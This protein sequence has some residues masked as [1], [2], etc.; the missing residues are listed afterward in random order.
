MIN[1]DLVGGRF[2]PYEMTY[3]WRDVILYN[4]GIGAKGTD[5]HYVYERV[6]GGLKVCPSFATI[7]SY[8]PLFSILE[9]LNI[10]L[11][12]LLHGEEFIKLLKPIPTEGKIIT[13]VKVA[14]IYDKVK[15]ALVE[16]ETISTDGEGNRLFETSMTLFCRGL[17]GWGGDPGP[18]RPSY[19]VPKDR[20]AD[21][22]VVEKISE[23]QAAIYRLSGDYNPLHIDPDFAKAAGLSQP[24]LHGLCTF[25]FA[26][27][28][29]IDEACNGNV[30]KLKSFGCRFSSVV[31][32]GDNLTISG[33][34]VEPG[35]YHMRVATERGDALS[36]VRAEV[37][38]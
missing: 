3:T 2:G 27:R 15:A 11:K 30:E 32:P 37:V 1:F 34:R 6:K 22:T 36:S 33:W 5:L 10:D 9:K 28:V 38:E 20:P 18:K 12:T 29:L 21:F 4:L 35:V 7:T 24:I 25:G 19:E 17:G 8:G 23:N 13:E 31:Y 16:L 14:G 26:V